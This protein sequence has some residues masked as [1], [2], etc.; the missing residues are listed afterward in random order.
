MF[1]VRGSRISGARQPIWKRGLRDKM[2]PLLPSVSLSHG[3]AYFSPAARWVRR[4]WASWPQVRWVLGGQTQK[5]GWKLDVNGQGMA[6]AFVGIGR[7]ATNM[8]RSRL[9]LR[10]TQLGYRSRMIESETICCGPSTC[11]SSGRCS[12]TKN[13]IALSAASLVARACPASVRHYTPPEVG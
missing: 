9:R 4:C 12:I 7:E 13:Q 3:I 1:A 8:A 10:A 11:G 2:Y 6:D 5:I